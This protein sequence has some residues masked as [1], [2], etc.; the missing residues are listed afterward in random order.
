MIRVAEYLFS[1]SV[2]ILSRRKKKPSKSL[3][4][5][6]NGIELYPEAR[7]SFEEDLVITY[8]GTD[9]KIVYKYYPWE[10]LQSISYIEPVNKTPK[11]NNRIELSL[12]RLHFGPLEGMLQFE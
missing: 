6:I 9:N 1:F 12:P 3:T 8:K 4:L 10:K 2:G 5:L 7:L 11:N